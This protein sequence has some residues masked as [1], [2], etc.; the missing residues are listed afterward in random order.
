M[1]SMNIQSIFTKFFKIPIILNVQNNFRIHSKPQIAHIIFATLQTI[2]CCC[3]NLFFANFLRSRERN[4][5]CSIEV[6]AYVLFNL[7]NTSTTWIS[8]GF[9]N[10]EGKYRLDRFF[11]EINIISD[12]LRTCFC[13]SIATKIYYR[14]INFFAFAIL[15]A[16]LWVILGTIPTYY[17]K[18]N[19]GTLLILLISSAIKAFSYTWVLLSLSMQIVITWFVMDQMVILL[20]LKC[21]YK[22]IYRQIYHRIFD[23]RSS[24]NNCFELFSL[25]MIIYN[26]EHIVLFLWSKIRP[27]YSCLME[28]STPYTALCMASSIIFALLTTMMRAAKIV[29][30]YHLSVAKKSFHILCRHW[31]LSV[32]IRGIG[33]ADFDTKIKRVE[34]LEANKQKKVRVSAPTETGVYSFRSHIRINSND[35]DAPFPPNTKF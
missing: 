17:S 4:S 12:Q 7:L 10:F 5:A 19:F 6:L 16:M 27:Q 31:P 30:T 34:Y 2:C 35:I 26:L 24:L 18:N 14:V 28:G 32:R 8:I 22:A 1:S 25:A 23:V 20:S 21:K 13:T 15:M 9:Y 3:T 29:S 11:S 33:S